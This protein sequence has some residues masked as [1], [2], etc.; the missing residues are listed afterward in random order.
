MSA[1]GF[2][3]SEIGPIVLYV[4]FIPLIFVAGAYLLISLTTRA[5]PDPTGRRPMGVYYFFAAFF[6]LWFAFIGAIVVVASLV[7]L[8][9]TNSYFGFS[10]EIH[11]IGDAA[12]RAVSIGLLIVIVAGVMHLIHRHRGLDLAEGESDPASPTKR[13][14]RSYVSAVSFITILILVIAVIALCYSVLGLIAPGVYLAGSRTDVLKDILDELFIIALSSSIFV[15][16]QRLAPPRLR[17]LGGP[18]EVIEVDIVEV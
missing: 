10:S 1:E 6:T 12:A 2:L 5:D 9:G 18:P 14:A 8:I 3:S 11:P 7:N 16:H 17:L 15:H 4:L 13:V